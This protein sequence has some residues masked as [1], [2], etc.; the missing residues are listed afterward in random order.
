MYVIDIVYTADLSVIDQYL[1]PH[2]EYLDKNYAK[3]LLLCSGPKN[4]RNGGTIIGLFKSRAEVDTFIQ[5]DPFSIHNIAKYSV[6][7][8]VPVKCHA[9]IKELCL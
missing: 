4:P 2:R 7:E 5:N 6:S 1:I 8:F 9:L 3:G